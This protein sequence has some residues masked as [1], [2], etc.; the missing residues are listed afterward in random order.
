MRRPSIRALSSCIILLHPLSAQSQQPCDPCAGT[1]G[2]TTFKVMPGTNCK[3]YSQ[4][5]NGV[6]FG[7]FQCSGDTVYDEA[8]QYCNWPSDTVCVETTCPPTRQPSTGRPTMNWEDCVNP[9]PRGFTG[10]QTRPGTNCK[11]YVLCQSGVVMEELECFGDTL[12]NEMVS[13]CDWP[14]SYTCSIVPCLGGEPIDPSEPTDPEQPTDPPTEKPTSNTV[15]PSLVQES[16]RPTPEP[17]SKP[18]PPSSSVFS[19]ATGVPSNAPFASTP[20]PGG[21]TTPIPASTTDEPTSSP[22]AKIAT[23]S[24]SQPSADSPLPVSSPEIVDQTAQAPTYQSFRSYLV[25]REDELNSVVFQSNGSPSTAY[26]FPDFLSSLDIATF[27]VPADKAFFVGEGMSGRLPKGIEYGLVNLAAFLSNAM[28][29]GIRFD[30][31]DEWNTD[32]IFDGP[33]EKY[34]LSNACGQYGRS[35]EDEGC[36]GNE[37][38]DVDRTMNV[39]ATDGNIEKNAP[40]FTCRPK[41]YDG[42]TEIFPGYFDFGD[43][44]VVK[45]TAY[46]NTV[47][48]TDLEGCC[49][50]GRGVLLTRGTCMYGKMSE[51]LGQGATDRGVFVYPDIDFCSTP[52]AICNHSRTNELRWVLGFLEWSDRVS[53]YVDVNTGWS[54]MDQMKRFVDSG[55][56]DSSFINGATNI[57]TRHCHDDSCEDRLVWDDDNNDSQVIRRDNFRKIISEVFRLPMTYQPTDAPSKSPSPTYSPTDEPDLTALPPNAAQRRTGSQLAAMIAAAWLSFVAVI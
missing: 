4:C 42:L 17:T 24:T 53:S 5:I 2:S 48:R 50:W 46:A 52:D 56:E 12:F 28:E 49:W 16:K 30:S 43:G 9:C 3:V 1:V 44:N 36:R 57:F 23:V 22:T 37:T 47:G 33:S 39:T 19:P 7:E 20:V 40:P 18:K 54:Y 15:T 34:P 45:Q 6:N 13:Y 31:C 11:K 38:C 27:Q 35:Y 32:F 29:E 55:M 8:K 25:D 41:E 26:T 21:E 10:F 14:G 51:L